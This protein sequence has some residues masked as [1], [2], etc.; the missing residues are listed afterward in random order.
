MNANSTRLILPPP[1]SF[2]TLLPRL[3]LP[4]SLSLTYIRS[5]FSRLRLCLSSSRFS[6]VWHIVHREISDGFVYFVAALANVLTPAEC[7]KHLPPLLPKL[8][9]LAGLGQFAHHPSLKVTVWRSLPLVLEALPL[10]ILK[11]TVDESM[12][13]PLV[14]ALKMENRLAQS[15]AAECWLYIEKKLGRGI[16]RGRLEADQLKAVENSMFIPK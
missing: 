5:L 2:A 6:L 15:A 12:L 7:D 1:P 11:R 13:E 14:E 9:T 16:A 4:E 3:A 8:F 10:T